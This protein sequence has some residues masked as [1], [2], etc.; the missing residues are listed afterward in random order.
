MQRDVKHSYCRRSC[1][2]R[3]QTSE[4]RPSMSETRSAHNRPG[5]PCAPAADSEPGKTTSYAPTPS[6]RCSAGACASFGPK[7]RIVA[8]CTNRV[9]AIA[10]DSA[11]QSMA[12]LITRMI[13][14]ASLLS[15]VREADNFEVVLQMRFER[16]LHAVSRFQDPRKSSRCF[17][18]RVGDVTPEHSPQS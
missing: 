17:A 2:D 11:Q 8:P 13:L 10:G 5:F 3:P 4:S 1:A 18:H 6:I 15:P 9:C 14:T 16:S 12:A 7:E